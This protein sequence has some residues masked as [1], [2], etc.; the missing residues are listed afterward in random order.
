MLTFR[1]IIPGVPMTKDAKY[2]INEKRINL[3]KHVLNEVKRVTARVL[4]QPAVLGNWQLG[5]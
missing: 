1:D 3:P 2:N 5:Q 4:Q